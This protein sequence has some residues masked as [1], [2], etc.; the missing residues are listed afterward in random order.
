M[1]DE[2]KH[3]VAQIAGIL[4]VKRG[5]LYGHLDKASIGG[6]PRAAK[7]SA[8][9]T[10]ATVT[11]P[12]ASNPPLADP[13]PRPVRARTRQPGEPITAPEQHL[14]DRVVRQRS[15]MRVPAC[16]TCGNEPVEARDRWQQRPDLAITWLYP[17]PEHP[18]QLIQQRHCRQCQPHQHITTLECAICGDGP[19]LTGDL[20]TSSP[21]GP[22]P[23]PVS[24]W[25]ADTGWRTT[26]E[27]I[28]P[29]HT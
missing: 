13:L 24:R 3:T 28:C 23:D 29:H 6:R 8:P 18:D 12:A 22:L 16:P 1:Y 7:T 5:T 20:A 10:S 27:L 25:L 11:T 14:Q 19:F 21:E 2:G 26:P 17:D 15:S 4:N 9:P